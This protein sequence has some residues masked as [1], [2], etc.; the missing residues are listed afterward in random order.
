MHDLKEERF[1]L[2]F[3]AIIALDVLEHVDDLTDI[4]QQFRRLLKPGGIVVISGPTENGLYKLGRRIAGKRFTGDYHVSNIG[5]IE[6]ECRRIGL[7]NKIA[8][9]YPMLPLF[10]VF[11]LQFPQ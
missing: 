2:S 6:Q 8:T 11:S 4:L 1:Q 3:D 9:I 7:V 5:R 10:K